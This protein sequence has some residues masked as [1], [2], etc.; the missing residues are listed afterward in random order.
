MEKVKQVLYENDV[1][2]IDNDDLVI[3]I[4][5]LSKYSMEVFSTR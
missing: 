1:I 4:I 5:I 2:R 3:N